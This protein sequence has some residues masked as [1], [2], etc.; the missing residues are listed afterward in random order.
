MTYVKRLQLSVSL[1][2]NPS[3]E[4][5]RRSFASLVGNEPLAGYCKDVVKLL[6]RPLLGLRDKEED[7]DESADIQAGI[8]SKSASRSKGS[9]DGWEGD[10]QD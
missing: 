5:P 2:Q 9:E 3:L 10:G 6:Q 4:P 8:E 7:H 1:P